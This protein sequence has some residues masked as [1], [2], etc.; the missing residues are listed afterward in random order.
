MQMDPTCLPK[1]TVPT[2]ELFEF[3]TFSSR[4]FTAL[5]LCSRASP[6]WYY[7]GNTRAQFGTV[8]LPASLT[9]P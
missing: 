4:G 2:T 1:E 3:V 9:F 5:L 7:G 6:V 8:N